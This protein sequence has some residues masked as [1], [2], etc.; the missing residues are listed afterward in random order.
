MFGPCTALGWVALWLPNTLYVALRSIVEGTDWDPDFGHGTGLTTRDLQALL[1]P[2]ALPSFRSFSSFGD[3]PAWLRSGLGVMQ[4]FEVHAAHAPPSDDIKSLSGSKVLL[5]RIMTMTWR[6]RSLQDW[7]KLLWTSLVA[8]MLARLYQAFVAWSLVPLGPSWKETVSW[9]NH[10]RQ[11]L[12]LVLAHHHCW[13]HDRVWECTHVN[14]LKQK[15]KSTAI[16]P[17]ASFRHS[18][19]WKLPIKA[20]AARL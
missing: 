14:S 2:K 10:H 18:E 19:N 16:V 3:H 12:F 9:R 4:S 7:P 1:V 5:C 6:R 13:Q 11:R 20:P 8:R 17:R 15:L